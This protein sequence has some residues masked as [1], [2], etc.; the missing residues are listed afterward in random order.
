MA[1]IAQELKVGIGF[2]C[3]TF[4]SPHWQ[5]FNFKNNLFDAI[6]INNNDP[7]LKENSVG[8]QLN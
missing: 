1:K 3:S 8:C 2:D 5:A 7:S 6:V 4:P